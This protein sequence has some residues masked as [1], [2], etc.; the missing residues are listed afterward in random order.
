MITLF[1]ALEALEVGAGAWT[2]RQIV[3]FY[4]NEHLRLMGTGK[5]QQTRTSVCARFLEWMQAPRAL[6]A[7]RWCCKGLHA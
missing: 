4:L 6:S 2:V 5:Q 1:A 7:R 3:G